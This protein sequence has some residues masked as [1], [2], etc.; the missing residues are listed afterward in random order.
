MIILTR[1]TFSSATFKCY[2]LTVVESS[3]V[4]LL[5]LD[6]R[7]EQ[8]R[9]IIIIRLLSRAATLKSCVRLSLTTVTRL[10][11]EYISWWRERENDI[12]SLDS[13]NPFYQPFSVLQM[14]FAIFLQITRQLLLLNS[15]SIW[16]RLVDDSCKRLLII[17]R[18]K[19]S[20]ENKNPFLCAHL[21]F[22]AS[23]I[24]RSLDVVERRNCHH[25][26]LSSCVLII[27]S[28]IARQITLAVSSS[29]K[30]ELEDLFSW[31][32]LSSFWFFWRWSW[33]VENLSYSLF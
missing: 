12:I 4:Q 3:D 21:F 11:D 31:I 14:Q 16:H 20:Y 7:R 30:I 10:K 32:N 5:L 27:K 6:C 15:Y 33:V 29:A 24:K 13:Q 25:S 23:L 9:S 17:Y 22:C 2:Y 8:R 28:R 18:E 19:L 26:F 1:R